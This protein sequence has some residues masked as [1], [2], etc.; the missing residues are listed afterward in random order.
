MYVFSGS[1]PRADDGDIQVCCIGGSIIDKYGWFAI[2]W[3]EAGGFDYKIPSS[4]GI[5][6]AK[7][8]LLFG[9][10]QHIEKFLI[11]TDNLSSV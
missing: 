3:T 6:N 5:F 4:A 7:L 2:H 8:S 10:L 9:K 11:L 1:S